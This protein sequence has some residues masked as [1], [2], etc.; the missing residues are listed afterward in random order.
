[1]MK[2]Q[3]RNNIYNITY[4]AII[5]VVIGFFLQI[6][7]IKIYYKQIDDGIKTERVIIEEE[8]EY[9][10]TV[11]D[12]TQVFGHQ[13]EV[14]LLQKPVP[15][16]NHFANVKQYVERSQA[17][18]LFRQH[19]FSKNRKNGMGYTIC[20]MKPLS[21]LHKF[22]RV[23]MLSISFAFLL[24]LIAFLGSGYFVNRQLWRPFYKTLDGLTRFNLDAPSTLNFTDTEISEFKQLNQIISSFSQKLKGD[25]IR[26]KEFTENLS[27]EINTMLAIIMSKVELLLQK[28]DMTE[29]QIEH[30]TTIYH[31]T[32]N[33]IH[34][35][36]GLLL[37]AKIDNQFYNNQEP[38][39]LSQLV[40][41]HLRT[42]DDFIRQKNL[43]VKTELAPV[44]LLMNRSL[45]EILISNM[46]N[47][48][49]KH[50]V[51]NGYL[52]INL[53]QSSIC[54]ENSCNDKENE[55]AGNGDLAFYE[56]K[57]YASL[58]LGFEIMKRICRIYDFSLNYTVQQGV[59]RLEIGFPPKDL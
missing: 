25:Y 3:A 24:L 11:P 34:L 26:M 20:I 39:E 46:M 47:N 16:R 10:D 15:Y 44:S 36:N 17:N 35:N 4:S 53:L 58:G 23:V 54:V 30:F 9:L 52:H 57:P 2:L 22:K 40:T 28:E 45:A 12:Y 13:I 51:P 48:A 27:H 31:V 43:E 8:I 59:Y 33:L 41:N 5:L 7:L 37:L 19:Y 50:N 21:E 1:M 42:F 56:N 49:I 29:D 6:T 55:P 32:N 14:S 38:I 18:E